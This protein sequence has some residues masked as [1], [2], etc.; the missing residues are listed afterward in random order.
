M[1]CPSHFR[2]RLFVLVSLLVLPGLA[3]AEYVP[4]SAQVPD[5]PRETRAAW[6]AT[7]HNIDWPSRRGLSGEAQRKELAGLLDLAAGAGLNAV[8]L[9]VRTE[10]D[11]LY[12]SSIEPWS[13]WLTGQMGKAPSDGY[14]PLAFA[15]KEAHRRGIELHAWF[16]PYRASA[17]KQSAKS[18]KHISRTHPQLMLP[19]GSQVW[20]NPGESYVQDRAI[21][22][23]ADV[24][25]RYDIDAIHIDDYFY[26][27]PEGGRQVYDD[28]ATYQRYKSK[29]GRLSPGDWRRSQTDAFVERLYRTVKSTKAPVKVG[30]SPFGIWRPG[31]PSGIEAGVDAYE[32]LCADSRKWLQRG[33]LDYLSPQLYW[34]IGGPQD[35]DKLSRWWA[36][37]SGKGRHVWPGIATSR[38]KSSEDRSRPAAEML[39]QIAV[40]RK[41]AANRQ[42]AGH[43]HWSI[44]ALREN[45]DGIRDKLASVYGGSVAI[46]PASPWLG[47]V[48]PSG[49]YVAPEELADGVRLRFKPAE[50]ARWRLIQIRREKG[51]EWVS[52]RLIPGGQDEFHLKEKP[53]EIALRNV[54]ATGILSRPT[55]LGR[56]R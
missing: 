12:K 38:I 9:Q 8:V 45:R 5:P 28:S 34:R 56:K 15:V 37:Q 39:N 1:A 46:P 44:K 20:A 25:K 23:M 22:V 51:G 33:W 32:H 2:F 54:S 48:E 10:C 31:Q 40:T 6:I 3:R 13:Y 49:C 43:V 52:L 27:Y 42:G 36:Q 30:I 11:A 18:S 35:F 26:P 24:V 55:V 47:S 50:D 16:N 14:D 53:G 21:E 41:N 19:A 4:V 7:V 29:G 17:S